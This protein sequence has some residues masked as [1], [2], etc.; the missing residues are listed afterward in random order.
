MARQL[1]QFGR[2][3]GLS[4]VAEVRHGGALL[5]H[6]GKLSLEPQYSP[7]PTQKNNTHSNKQSPGS[8]WAASTHWAT[9]RNEC[10]WYG[11]S[12]GAGAGEIIREI[13]LPGNGLTGTIPSEAVLAGVG[14]GLAGLDLSEN[15]VGG[16]VP[17]VLGLFANLL[18]LDL[19]DSEF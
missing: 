17:E 19:R 15:A 18:V 4:E 14:G 9:D 2:A 11:A 6:D 7:A 5:R 10:D 13:S 3:L 12:C 8:D 16:T 1:G